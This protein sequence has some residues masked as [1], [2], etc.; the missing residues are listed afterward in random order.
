MV[1]G[2]VDF[3][4][5]VRRPFRDFS[6]RAAE[7]LEVVDSGLIDED[8]PVGKEQDALLQPS[9]PQS[10]DDLESRVRLPGSGRHDQQHSVLSQRDGLDRAVDGVEL[11]VPGR[12]ATAV[13]MEVVRDDLLR[14]VVETLPLAVAAPQLVG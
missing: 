13:R 14:R 10:P 2:K 1:Q 6:H 12:L 7:R 3:V 11:V 4:R 9:L 5:L 8:V